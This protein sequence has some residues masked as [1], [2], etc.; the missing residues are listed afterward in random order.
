[1]Y[2]L[3]Q[4]HSIVLFSHL[5][6]IHGM[7]AVHFGKIDCAVAPGTTV[8]MYFTVWYA[9]IHTTTSSTVYDIEVIGV[10]VQSVLCAHI[11]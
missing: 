4:Y 5:V 3:V 2:Y 1:M 8:F 6:R 11:I 10:P 7:Y 9:Y